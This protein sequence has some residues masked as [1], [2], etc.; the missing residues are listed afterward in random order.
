MSLGRVSK[1]GFSKLQALYLTWNKSIT[2]Q[3]A[4]SIVLFIVI[5]HLLKRFER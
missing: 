3:V 5:D 1:F 2:G 4:V